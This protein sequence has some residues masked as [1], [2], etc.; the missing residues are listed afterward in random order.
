MTGGQ[1]MATRQRA[2]LA[3]DLGRVR[4]GLAYCDERGEVSLALEVWQRKGTRLDIDHIAQCAARLSTTVFVLGLPP[5]QGDG[6][7][8]HQLARNFAQALRNRLELPVFMVDEA[9]TS[10]QAH[11]E[12]AAQGMRAAQRRTVI[13]KH[14]AQ[15][16]LD[17][18]LGGWAAEEILPSIQAVPAIT[19][20]Q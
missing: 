13:D 16:I 11:A 7:G 5:D 14:A 17:R 1:A 20:A 18:W 2:A 10:V 4:L 12:L 8:T 15:R 9:D 3:V 19:G 6:G